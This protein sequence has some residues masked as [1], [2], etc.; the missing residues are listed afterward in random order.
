MQCKQW[1][2]GA[3]K[4]PA[5]MAMRKELAAQIMNQIWTRGFFSCSGRVSF[6]APNIRCANKLARYKYKGLVWSASL[7]VKQIAYSFCWRQRKRKCVSQWQMAC[8]K[9][10]WTSIARVPDL[11]PTTVKILTHLIFRYHLPL[12][13]DIYSNIPV[14][15]RKEFGLDIL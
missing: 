15:K 12:Q 9:Q 3:L 6:Y 13:Y 2:K 4:F 1:S 14:N 5:S 11:C 10:K 7:F 8:S